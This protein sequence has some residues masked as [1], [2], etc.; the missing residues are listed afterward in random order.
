MQEQDNE[1]WH[2]QDYSGKNAPPE[3]EK[4]L[5]W[6]KATSKDA[7]EIFI[8]VGDAIRIYGKETIVEGFHGAYN[9]GLGKW[10]T[11]IMTTKRGDPFERSID[12]IEV[13]ADKPY[14]PTYTV[15]APAASP[16]MEEIPEEFRE[17]IKRTT[18]RKEFLE[19]TAEIVA[20]QMGYIHGAQSAYRKLTEKRANIVSN[21]EFKEAADNAYFAVS[22]VTDA[23]TSDAYVEGYLAGKESVTLPSIEPGEQKEPNKCVCPD[24]A[25]EHAGCDFPDCDRYAKKEFTP[26]DIK[27]AEPGE[28]GEIPKMDF[29]LAAECD[30]AAL[31]FGRL[32]Q[33]CCGDDLDIS[34]ELT[35][36]FE[37]GQSW[38]YRKQMEE[39]PQT[40]NPLAS[41][42]FEKARLCLVDR[43][44][45]KG[46]LARANE[47]I[48]ELQEWHDSH[49]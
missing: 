21:E 40:E 32:H 8:Q 4:T 41:Y 15:E 9:E 42:W 24:Y 17:W 47:K 18:P 37:A 25:G 2:P 49:L 31:D 45:F 20:N 30:I 19:L 13:D 44:D 34:A 3:R 23:R 27:L 14:R 38:M 26:I 48:K 43:N 28:K 10:E 33:R 39:M 35:E 16:V 1:Q 29:K 6:V 5:R 12:V 7:E 22:T 46:Q 11:I 36:A